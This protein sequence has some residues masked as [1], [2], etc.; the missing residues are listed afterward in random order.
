[1]ADPADWPHCGDAVA[2]RLKVLINYK[3]WRN[4]YMLIDLFETWHLTPGERIW[5]VFGKKFMWVI[6][7]NTTMNFVI[8]TV[9][10]DKSR[11][12]CVSWI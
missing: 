12:L 4:W 9:W 5:T 11:S 10:T 6:D 2:A 7:L 1:V 8:C 3:G